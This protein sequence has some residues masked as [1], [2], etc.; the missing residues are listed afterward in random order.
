MVGIVLTV[1]EIVLAATAFIS[2]MGAHYALKVTSEMVGA[3]A[4]D[5]QE[6][7]KRCSVE[8]RW[9]T[10]SIASSLCCG[11]IGCAIASALYNGIPLFR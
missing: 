5:T 10:T 6:Y 3:F 11:L 9:K 2:W 7:E 4:V 1:I 8:Q